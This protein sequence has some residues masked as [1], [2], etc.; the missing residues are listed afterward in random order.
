MKNAFENPKVIEI[1]ADQ[2]LC[3]K[4]KEC[5]MLLEQVGLNTVAKP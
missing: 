4:L 2:R 1:C 5:N 3:D